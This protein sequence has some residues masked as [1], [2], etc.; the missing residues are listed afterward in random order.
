MKE[1][2]LIPGQLVRLIVKKKRSIY[3]K[4]KYDNKNLH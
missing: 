3:E 1:G 2:E 4:A